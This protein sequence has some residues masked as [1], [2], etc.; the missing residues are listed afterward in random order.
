MQ[1]EVCLDVLPEI[2]Q[3]FAVNNETKKDLKA[4]EGKLYVEEV[5]HR[6]NEN[7]I[8]AVFIHL[9]DRTKLYFFAKSLLEKT[10]IVNVQ[11]EHEPNVGDYVR[12]RDDKNKIFLEGV[13]TQRVF[14]STGRHAGYRYLGDFSVF[15]L[16]KDKLEDDIK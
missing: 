15:E 7:G 13:I 4:G 6:Q 11:L 16:P 14:L 5:L 2:G 3:A 10:D 8:F 1:K 12:F 9:I